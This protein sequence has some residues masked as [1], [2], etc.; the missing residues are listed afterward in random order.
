M[1]LFLIEGPL[2]QLTSILTN[3]KTPWYDALGLK[4][5]EIEN[6]DVDADFHFNAAGRRGIGW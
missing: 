3:R 1:A 6:I 4:Y 5:I 2:F